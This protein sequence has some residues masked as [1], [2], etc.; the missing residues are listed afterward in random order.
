MKIAQDHT[1]TL[2]LHG[3]DQKRKLGDNGTFIM[4]SLKWTNS[5]MNVNVL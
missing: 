1:E 4:V 5:N 3:C 2:A